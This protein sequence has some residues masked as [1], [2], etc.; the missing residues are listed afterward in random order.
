MTFTVKLD[1]ALVQALYS[2]CASVGRTA[3]DVI[4]DALKRYL[5][6]APLRAPSAHELGSDLFDKYAGPKDLASKRKALTTQAWDD[7][8]L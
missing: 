5:A 1:A 8:G 3:D 6:Q 7:I 4:N 2:H